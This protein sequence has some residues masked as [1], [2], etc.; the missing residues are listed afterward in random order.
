MSPI[1]NVSISNANSSSANLKPEIMCYNMDASYFT[2]GDF[3]EW[4]IANCVINAVLAI[5]AILM[6]LLVLLA[7]WKSPAL[8]SPSFGILFCLALSDLGVGLLAQP[9][10]LIYTVAKIRGFISIACVNGAAAAVLSTYLCGISILSIT[11]VS[12]DRYLALHLHLR[13]KQLVTN[14]RVITVLLCI[15]FL[16]A[17]V[18][19]VWLWY[20]WVISIIAVSVGIFCI[21]VTAFC[22]SHI[23]LILRRHQKHISSHPRPSTINETSN[24]VLNSKRYNYSVLGMFMVYILLLVCYIPYLSISCAIA[25]QGMTITKRLLFELA[26][27]VVYAN[28]ALNPFMYCWRLRDIRA[29]VIES[30]PCLYEGLRMFQISSLN[31][32]YCQCYA[33]QRTKPEHNVLQMTLRTKTQNEASP[34]LRNEDIC[35]GIQHLSSV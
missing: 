21:I 14:K 1:Q 26:R 2:T 31:I 10:V 12:I 24:E 16:V 22:F 29:A 30:L 18:L 6:N 27:T 9:L 11:A 28:S 13:Y 25:A 19:L 15:W 32:N 20:P 35:N 23:Y 3:L 34:T 7:I 33:N 4:Y 8:H 5:P 17:V